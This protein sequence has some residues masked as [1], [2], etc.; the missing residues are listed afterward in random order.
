MRLQFIKLIACSVF[1][2]TLG[3][4]GREKWPCIDGVGPVV[5]ETRSVS[6][7]TEISNEMEAVLY[8][9]Q[10]P[11]YSVRIEAQQNILDQVKTALSGST[12]E[13]YSEHCIDKG[14]PVNVY[15][16]LPVLTV[17]D[18]S[19]S[20]SAFTQSNFSG[21]SLNIDISGSGSFT[22]T[23]SIT[24]G[25]LDMDISGSGSLNLLAFVTT[26]SA[27]IS[28]SG[29]VTLSG[30]GSTIS[31]D[32]SGSGKMATFGFLVNSAYVEV[33][34]SGNIE[35]NATDLIDG[36]INGSG[37]IYYKNSPVINVEIS[38]SGSLIHIP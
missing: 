29:S 6:G 35:L 23:D 18:I 9:T 5:T 12:L 20:G 11:E 32:I 38:G 30:S 21:A 27:D 28:G 34:G 1:I 33:S 22:S 37:D 36:E 16:T 2:I 31:Q 26:A 17:L 8:I 10:G 19:G 14:E 7:F 15:I 4:C 3:S 24:V 25:V 13:I